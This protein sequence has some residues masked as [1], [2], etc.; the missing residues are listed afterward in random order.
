[1]IH[2][3]GFVV[4]SVLL[5]LAPGPDSFLV[6]RNAVL[7]GRRDGMGTVAGSVAGT[8]IW[9]VLAGVGVAGLLSASAEAYAA[10]KIAGAVY[11]LVLG[12]VTLLGHD[13]SPSTGTRPTGSRP[14][15][16][17]WAAARSGLTVDLLNPKV[18]MFFVAVL[19]QFIGASAPRWAPL[20]LGAVDGAIAAVWLAALAVL[21]HRAARVLS[22]DRAR[23]T[24]RH[25]TGLALVGFGVRLATD[26]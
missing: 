19:P 13:K 21:A 20:A 1:M 11:L 5:T 2:W 15:R 22:T 24:L 4:F 7:R 17:G 8:L 9:A 26:S 23:R 12:L 6:I 14:V 25:L 10:V 16:S 18:G 3:G